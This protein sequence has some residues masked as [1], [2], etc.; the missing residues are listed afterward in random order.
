[1]SVPKGQADK[2]KASIE[3]RQPLMAPLRAGQAVATLKLEFDGQPFRE[4][5]VVALENAD[6]AGIFGRGWDT[7]RLLFK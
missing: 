1:V 7:M 6:I 5:R 3:S 4:T 2:L